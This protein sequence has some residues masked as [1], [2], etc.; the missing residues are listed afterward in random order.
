MPAHAQEHIHTFLVRLF[1]EVE[2]VYST[3]TAFLTWLCYLN[4]C[5]PVYLYSTTYIEHSCDAGILSLGFHR[6]Q[7]SVITDCIISCSTVCFLFHVI[8]PKGRIY[9]RERNTNNKPTV[10]VLQ[11]IIVLLEKYVPLDR[12]GNFL[13]QMR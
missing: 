10:V 7:I 13:I 1:K 3:M 4:C 9:I 5:Q 2:V 6:Y 11:S 8:P 12:L